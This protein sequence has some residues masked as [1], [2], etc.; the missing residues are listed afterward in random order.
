MPAYQKCP[1]N[2]SA[3]RINPFLAKRDIRKAFPCDSRHNINTDPMSIVTEITT[4]AN[5]GAAQGTGI[6]N[7]ISHFKI[8]DGQPRRTFN[9]T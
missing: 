2:M 8:D 6:R 5:T 9:Q 1:T 4:G 3:T 7:N